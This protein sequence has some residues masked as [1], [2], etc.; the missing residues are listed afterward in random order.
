MSWESTAALQCAASPQALWE[1]LLDGRG[2]SR[3]LEGLEWMFVEGALEPGTLMTVKPRRFLQTALTIERVQ[4][5]AALA[6][7]TTFGPLAR[8]DVRFEI[9]A[10]EAGARIEQRVRVEGVLGEM[11]AKGLARKLAADE[12]ALARL[13]GLAAG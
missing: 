1:V 4:A 5:P 11:L 10:E 3:W 9:A 7:G 8:L 2:W 6:F 13:C 12:P